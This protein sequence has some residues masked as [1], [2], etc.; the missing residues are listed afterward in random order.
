MSDAIAD[1]DA[2]SRAPAGG[3]R[4]L[5]RR[6]AAYRAA[7]AAEVLNALDRRLAARV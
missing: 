4:Q 6:L 2:H 7:D 5:A 3:P 1:A